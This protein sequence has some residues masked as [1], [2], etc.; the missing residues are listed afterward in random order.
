MFSD[1][2]ISFQLPVC[3][4]N[5]T[6]CTREWEKKKKTP[7]GCELFPSSPNCQKLIT[8][9]QRASCATEIKSNPRVIELETLHFSLRSHLAAFHEASFPFIQKFSFMRNLV[10]VSRGLVYSFVIRVVC[11]GLYVLFCLFR[12]SCMFVFVGLLICY[13]SLLMKGCLYCVYNDLSIV[14]RQKY[15]YQVICE[16]TNNRFIYNYLFLGTV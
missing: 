4:A 13:F 3:I 11:F 14:K 5:C 8:S 7:E 1:Q 16:I 6:N 9:L 2:E 12:V 15:N 10:F